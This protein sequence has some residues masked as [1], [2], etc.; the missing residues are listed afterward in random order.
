M[1]Y[2]EEP[3]FF[4]FVNNSN[5]LWTEEAAKPHTP[6]TQ[7]VFEDAMLLVYVMHVVQCLQSS[8]HVRFSLQVKTGFKLFNYIQNDAKIMYQTFIHQYFRNRCKYYHEALCKLTSFQFNLI[9]G[10]VAQAEIH[11]TMGWTACVRS[12]QRI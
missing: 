3:V 5:I 2:V 1:E 11:L 7:W 4:S 12:L 6:E 8:D 9:M 10:Q